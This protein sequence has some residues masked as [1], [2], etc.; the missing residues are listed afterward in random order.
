MEWKDVLVGF[1]N[2]QSD[3]TKFIA[4]ITTP[5]ELGPTLV[6]MANSK[7]GTI[8]IGIDI[9]NYHLW[10]TK[11]D[12]EW[13]DKM[14]ACTIRPQLDVIPKFIE[15]NDKI[16]MAIKLF[17]GTQKPYYFNNVCYI[18]DAI[19]PKIA[20]LENQKPL[21]IPTEA[22]KKDIQENTYSS[23]DL[24]QLTSEL[25]ELSHPSDPIPSNTT[26]LKPYK[27]VNHTLELKKQAQQPLSKAAY[28]L[29]HRQK[30]ALEIIFEENSIRNKK[31]RELFK[32]SHKTA[33]LELVDMVSKG[34]ITPSGKG[35]S[36]CY[37]VKPVTA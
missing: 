13:V 9:K 1:K 16:I 34:Y 27:K 23:E 26:L 3:T 32:V 37:I 14:V 25:M 11:L 31:Y 17:E 36:I 6:G 5:E 12:R 24:S 30:N 18:M 33:H 20:L 4:V 28:D 8:F 15:K 2:G 19:N 22:Q 10:G 35:R 7:G 21:S 29:N